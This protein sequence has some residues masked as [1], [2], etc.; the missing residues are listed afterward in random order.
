MRSTKCT[1]EPIKEAPVATAK[2]AALKLL[3]DESPATAKLCVGLQQLRVFLWSPIAL[4]E[5]GIERFSVPLR[6]RI[7]CPP[8]NVLGNRRPFPSMKGIQV[9]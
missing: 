7:V 6:T 4:F 8:G 9:E 2:S 3:P 1:S 5:L